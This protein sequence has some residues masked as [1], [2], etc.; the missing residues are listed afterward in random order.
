MTTVDFQD[1]LI[2]LHSIKEIAE[3]D[4]VLDQ[5]NK[6]EFRSL[7]NEIFRDQLVLYRKICLLLQSL[8]KG[9]K[10]TEQER[11]DL[12]WE[13]HSI[14]SDIGNKLESNSRGVKD[15]EPKDYDE[16]DLFNI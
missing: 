6:E 4:L 3:I 1:F 15:Y 11:K 10:F 7:S 13:I 9:R 14:D 5:H 12:F 2:Y 8:Y 16:Y